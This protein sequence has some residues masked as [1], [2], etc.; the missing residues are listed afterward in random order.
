MTAAEKHL[1]RLQWEIARMYENHQLLDEQYWAEGR[2]ARWLIGQADTNVMKTEIIAGIC[3][4]LLVHGDCDTARFA[5][6]SDHRDAWRRLCWMGCCRDLG[7]YVA[8][9]YSIGMARSGAGSD[10]YDEEV[11]QDDLR[12]RIAEEIECGREPDD[13]LIVLLHEALESHTESEHE[14]RMFLSENDKGWDLWEWR[15]GEVIAT[16][17]VTGHLALQR[18]VYLLVDKYGWDGP[19]ACRRQP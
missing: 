6:Y 4:S 7:Y 14:L 19:P 9:K 10:T 15:F 16:P 3:G 1:R 13:P 5:Y 11:A 18:C 2:G 12:R 8:Q 17:V